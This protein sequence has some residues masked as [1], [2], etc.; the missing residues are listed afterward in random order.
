MA[1][2]EDYRNF[3]S[4]IRKLTELDALTPDDG[5][6]VSVRVE[7]EYNLNLQFIE[8]SN[9]ILCFVEVATLPKSAGKEV[10]RD[11]MGGGLFGKET[12][13]GYFT[14]EAETDTVVYNYLFE[15][16]QARRE[17]EEF[18]DTLERI[19]SLVDVWIQRI[20]ADIAKGDGDD[21]EAAIAEPNELTTDHYFRFNP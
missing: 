19:L 11:L 9:R 13:G 17:P 15:F 18:V 6:L 1:T 3:L 14:L 2:M 10:Y 5:G 12:G 20:E 7:D 16:D 8:A 21:S 4:E